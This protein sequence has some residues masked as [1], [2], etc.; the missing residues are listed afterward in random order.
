MK[1]AKTMRRNMKGIVISA[2]LVGAFAV[3]TGAARADARTVR[4]HDDG[5][6]SSD[7]RLRFELE[8]T[9]GGV[10]HSKV[11]GRVREFALGYDREGETVRNVRL[12][13]AVNAMDTG[14]DRRDEKM[15][16]FC[17]G[18]ARFPA[19]EVAIPGPLPVDA[20]GEVPARIKVRGRWHPIRVRLEARPG[21]SETVIE[22]RASVSLSAIGVPD[23]SIWIAH[24][25]D[26]VDIAFRMSF[27]SDGAARV[28]TAEPR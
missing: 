25:R 16:D 24:V 20:R 10:I 22:G 21:E 11:D 14:N 4:F 15:K 2:A 5:G 8:S 9:K 13:F 26:R 18:V 3:P 19:V 28:G 1:D 27:P 17:L 6:R 23:P 12:T 7:D